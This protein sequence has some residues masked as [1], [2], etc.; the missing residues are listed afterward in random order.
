MITSDELTQMKERA[1]RL[2][3]EKWYFDG[4][5]ICESDRGNPV[6][7]ANNHGDIM[8][9]QVVGEFIAHSREDVPR[10]VAEVERL[11][12]RVD[13][14]EGTIIE[15]ANPGTELMRVVEEDDE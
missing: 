3:T 11:Q 12:S 7:T 5:T 8:M 2:V 9:S 13:T 4:E 15:H 10:L 6:V 14:L 1:K